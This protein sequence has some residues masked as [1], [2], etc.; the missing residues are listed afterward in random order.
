[1]KKMTK[2]KCKKPH[3]LTI[4]SK[5]RLH[6]YHFLLKTSNL[7]EKFKN[8]HIQQSPTDKHKKSKKLKRVKEIPHEIQPIKNNFSPSPRKDYAELYIG[9]S[10]LHSLDK[11]R[12][13][14]SRTRTRKSS[15]SPQDEEAKGEGQ[16]Q[17]KEKAADLENDQVIKLQ[18]IHPGSGDDFDEEEVKNNIKYF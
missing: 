14:S 6:F 12:H 7:I 9:Q 2:V 1:M 4:K 16:H 18:I 3:R 13:R 11:R 5:L 15:S 8:K 10:S 17:A